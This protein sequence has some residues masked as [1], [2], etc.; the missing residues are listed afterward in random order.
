MRKKLLKNF[1]NVVIAHVPSL[2]KA[3]SMVI[4]K[5]GVITKRNIYDNWTG[6]IEQMI[7]H[8]GEPWPRK[9]MKSVKNIRNCNSFYAHY[10][11]KIIELQKN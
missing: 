3:T 11:T 6:L 5:L 9:P 8:L 4:Y 2:Q 7:G 1:M 10:I